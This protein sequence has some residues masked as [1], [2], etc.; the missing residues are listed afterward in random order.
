[1][2]S[3]RTR[4]KSSNRVSRN[5]L[6]TRASNALVECRLPADFLYM[7][8]GS[9]RKPLAAA[10]APALEHLAPIGR[11]HALA[12]TMHAHTAADL[13]LVRTFH[14][15]SFLTLKIITVSSFC[16]LRLAQHYTVMVS[17]RSIWIP[18]GQQFSVWLKKS[19]KIKRS[20]VEKE[21][22]NKFL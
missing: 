20:G 10:Q 15:F 18:V 22:E 17:I 3:R 16:P 4:L 2:P 21:R 11:G 14:H 6:C 19:L 13:R 5:F 9:H 8:V 7:I 12:E 1:M